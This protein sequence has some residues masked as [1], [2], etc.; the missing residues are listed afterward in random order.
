M[1]QGQR[2][3][4]SHINGFVVIKIEVFTGA[5][6]SIEDKNFVAEW[7]VSSKPVVAMTVLNEKPRLSKA[8]RDLMWKDPKVQAGNAYRGRKHYGGM[9]GS[10]AAIFSQTGGEVRRR[11]RSVTV[12]GLSQT[13]FEPR[14]MSLLKTLK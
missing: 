8:D 13:D 5:S 2:R 6:R 10:V 9:K 1:I 14:G 3:V 7:P 11:R 4:W 12:L